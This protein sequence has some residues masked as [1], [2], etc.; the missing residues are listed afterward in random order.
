[1]FRRLKQ[2]DNHHSQDNHDRSRT[3][4]QQPFHSNS[5]IPFQRSAPRPSEIRAIVIFPLRPARAGADRAALSSVPADS[6]V[7]TTSSPVSVR[8]PS[9]GASAGR[10]QRSIAAQSAAYPGG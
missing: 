3:N 6:I 7:A 8:A 2:P 4:D 1:M 5:I 9:A 10:R